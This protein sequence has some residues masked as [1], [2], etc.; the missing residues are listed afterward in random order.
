[1]KRRHFLSAASASSVALLLSACG[2]GDDDTRLEPPQDEET[3]VSEGV[4]PASLSSLPEPQHLPLEW[5]LEPLSEPLQAAV[6]IGNAP[7][8]DVPVA[9]YDVQ[10]QLLGQARTDAQGIAHAQGTARRL[11]VAQAQTAYGAIEGM[12]IFS[13]YSIEPSIQVDPLQTL[14]LAVTVELADA[15]QAYNVGRYALHDYFKLPHDVNILALGPHYH[16]LNQERLCDEWR[17]SGLTLA[18]YINSLKNDVLTHLDD[19]SYANT[20]FSTPPTRKANLAIGWDT[21]TAAEAAK[22]ARDLIAN[23]IP[24]PFVSILVGF[25]LDQLIGLIPRDKGEN[26]FAS[27]TD[28][29]VIIQS[30]INQMDDQIKEQGL[31][32]AMTAMME[33]F[34]EF[35]AVTEDMRKLL[36]SEQATDRGELYQAN[37]IKLSALSQPGIPSSR[38]KLLSAHEKWIGCNEQQRSSVLNELLTVVKKR[39]YSK[40][41]EDKYRSYIAFYMVHQSNAHLLLACSEIARG[42]AEGKSIKDVGS[43]LRRIAEDFQGIVTSTLALDVAPMPER[44]NIDATNKLAWLGVTGQVR[45]LADLWPEGKNASY[46]DHFEMPYCPDSSTCK[47][48]SIYKNVPGRGLTNWQGPKPQ[49]HMVHSAE[50]AVSLE[51]FRYLPWRN[52]SKDEIKHL[53]FDEASKTK[54]KID[55]YASENGFSAIGKDGH[56][57]NAFVD[58]LGQPASI[59][60]RYRKAGG[61]VFSGPEYLDMSCVALANYSFV[62]SRKASTAYQAGERQNSMAFFPVANLTDDQLKKHVPWLHV[63]AQRASGAVCPK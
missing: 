45:E 32:I 25:G 30:K 2:S 28:Q 35:R 14:V 38:D 57:I 49:P 53:F 56:T 4:D 62:D 43:A 36:V 58:H 8:P 29:L 15:G 22:L 46:F 7:Q 48:V 41:L 19:D 47:P 6:W 50:Q 11:V 13:G 17:A 24:I 55:V 23:A 1:M 31:R 34:S 3:I 5:L 12:H 21:D 27:I 42:R 51:T 39:Y 18:A 52:A 44:L 26:P 33:H 9:F 16:L 61:G 54:Q 20:R 40:V 10:G 63:A 37:L 59:S 60:F